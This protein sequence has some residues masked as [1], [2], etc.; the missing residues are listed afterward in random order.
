[1]VIKIQRIVFEKLQICLKSISLH[2]NKVSKPTDIFLIL[3]PI[4]ILLCF[5]HFLITTQSQR[6]VY[7][8][9]FKNYRIAYFVCNNLIFF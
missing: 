7:F 9:Y 4:I 6:T 8:L 2:T 1:M 3:A 5:T